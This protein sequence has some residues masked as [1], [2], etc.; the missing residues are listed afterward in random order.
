MSALSHNGRVYVFGGRNQGKT[1]NTCL[2]IDGEQKIGAGYWSPIAPMPLPRSHTIAVAADDRILVIG[3]EN[4]HATADTI[5]EYTPATC[6]W[7]VLPWKL[8][9]RYVRCVAAAYHSAT[10]TLMIVGS[11]EIG[12]TDI[13]RDDKPSAYAAWPDPF[14]YGPREPVLP[15]HV[16]TIAQPFEANTWVYYPK[17]QLP[18]AIESYCTRFCGTSGVAVPSAVS[19]SSSS[20]SSAPSATCAS[21]V[22]PIAM[23]SNVAH[24]GVFIFDG[25]ETTSIGVTYVST[26]Q[27]IC[28]RVT[29]DDA[30]A[31][32]GASSSSSSSSSD[33]EA[34][35]PSLAAWPRRRMFCHAIHMG[36][37]IYMVGGFKQEV[38]I[39]N[40]KSKTW[41]TGAPLQHSQILTVVLPI[42]N[43]GS[44][45]SIIAMGP[46]GVEL[47]DVPADVWRVLLPTADSRRSRAA[48]VSYHN[49]V[50]LFGGNDKDYHPTLSSEMYSFESRSTNSGDG[51]S[52]A[53]VT[54]TT[55]ESNV[56]S[57]VGIAA[58]PS[59]K[60]DATSVVIGDTIF[61]MGGAG[62]LR[63]KSDTIFEYTP[64]TDTWR[65]LPWRLPQ[66]RTYFAAVYD[67]TTRTL[68]IAGGVDDLCDD[69]S[70]SIDPGVYTIQQPFEHNEWTFHHRSTL[71]RAIYLHC[72]C[73]AVL[74]TPQIPASVIM[75]N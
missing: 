62:T 19:L 16:Y 53:E 28:A 56:W 8:P 48:A 71:G 11:H 43:V 70:F 74:H 59:Y 21:I 31:K 55:R 64:A 60:K 41:R 23:R 33:V 49:C 24:G 7:R 22:E 34:F 50:Y 47:Y 61:I 63:E 2:V 66:P 37:A 9:R 73:S 46:C 40:I 14:V 25:A 45:D 32:Y 13:T 15:L 1:L 10:R 36:D 17:Q 3:G 5:Q 26:S 39:F 44:G 72:Y 68:M 51:K 12:V 30:H 4:D 57:S 42:H 6:T 67:A 35:L 52:A 29:H 54:A 20:S 18:Y 38:D 65:L 58:M 27:S 69:L 75:I